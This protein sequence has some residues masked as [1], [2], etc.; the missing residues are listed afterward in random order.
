M[1]VRCGSC[2]TQF[3]APSEGRFACPACG[4]ANEVRS[5]PGAPGMVAPAPPVAPAPEPEVPSPRVICSECDFSFIVGQVDT[6]PCP[7]CGSMVEV[8]SGEGSAS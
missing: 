4:T 1:I 6:A 2:Q 5:Q 3:D 8:G 7:M